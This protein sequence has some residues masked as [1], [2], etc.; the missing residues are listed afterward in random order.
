MSDQL[1]NKEAKA[2]WAYSEITS[3][4]YGGAFRANLAPEIVALA[5]QE[6]PFAKVP[7]E[8]HDALIHVLS[9]YARNDGFIR[10]LD[11]SPAYKKVS[12]TRVQLLKLWALW[13]FSP[14]ERNQCR[15]YAVFHNN[16]GEGPDDPRSIAATIQNPDDRPQT[17]AGIVMNCEGFPVLIEG[18][19]RSQIFM[20]STDPSRRFEVWW[21]IDVPAP[22]E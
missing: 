12:L 22:A 14:P 18:Y 8:H 21:P 2:R 6:V 9:N 17:E 11:S 4:R 10:N 7:A 16:P 1:T 15:S 13:T 19:L 5:I 3:S 20:K